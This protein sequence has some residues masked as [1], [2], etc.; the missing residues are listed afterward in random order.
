VLD[1]TTLELKAGSEATLALSAQPEGA[2]TWKSSN[3]SIA[4]VKD[5]LVKTFQAGSATLTVSAGD[6]S[7]ACELTV[8]SRGTYM[9]VWREDFNELNTSVWNVEVD[10]G[11]SG[12][13]ELQYYTDRSKNIRIENGILVIE[14]HKEKYENNDYTSARINTQGKKDFTYGKIEASIQL[15]TEGRGTWPAFWMLGYP[16]YYG[17]WPACG[18]IDI[19]EYVGF[20]PDTVFHTLHS[21][22]ASGGAGKQ[23]STAVPGASTGFHTYSVEWIQNRDRYGDYIHFLVDGKEVRGQYA[24]FS[25]NRWPFDKPFYI[26]L[27][28]AIGGD[29][30]GARKEPDGKGG[31]DNG[32]DDTI[33]NN[34]VQMKVDWVRVYQYQ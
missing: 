24:E 16:R 12:N 1:Q 9:E 5:G 29:W 6:Q 7:A 15:L 28:L 2:L 19:M 4:T 30:G 18:E 34:P 25:F 20:Q 10:G 11:G 21:P 33:F 3:E 31:V 22:G 32:V 26:I 8:T 17:T 13:H 27:N 14:A 23:T